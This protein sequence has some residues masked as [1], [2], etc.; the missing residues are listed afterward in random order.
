MIELKDYQQG[1]QEWLNAR[2]NRVTCSN[3]LLL[4]EKGKHACLLANQDAAFRVSPNGNGYAERGHVLEN[5][6]REALNTQLAEKNYIVRETGLLINDKYPDAAYS[7]D[8][9]V[10]HI[11][12]ASDQYDAIV[13]I[14]SYND[15]VSRQYDAHSPTNPYHV[16]ADNGEYV[17]KEYDSSGAKTAD[18][19]VGK[20]AKACESYNNVPLNARLQIQMEL[21]ISEAPK[22]YLVLYNPDATGNTP[23]VKV[24]TIMPDAKYQKVLID[25][26][27]G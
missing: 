2:L 17:V 13:E 8:G 24:Y 21:L 1:S 7:P 11:D 26:L 27:K 23:K 20:H 9:L 22:C 18:V 4:V 16:N 15:V 14:K 12:D 6:V 3:A 5:E 10:C 19:Y 25:K